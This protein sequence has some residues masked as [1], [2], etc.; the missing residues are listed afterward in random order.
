MMDKIS[1]IFNNREIATAVWIVVALF[2]VSLKSKT[3]Y[4]SVWGFL[5]R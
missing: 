2:F 1:Q 5:P 3:F 4:R